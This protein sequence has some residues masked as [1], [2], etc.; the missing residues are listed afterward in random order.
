M[1]TSHTLRQPALPRLSGLIVACLAATWLIWGS[2]YLAIKWALVSLPP[3]FQMGTRFLAAA[4]VL[5]AWAAWHGARWPN[6]AQWLSAGVLGALMVLGG[7]G[8]TALAQTHVSSGLI[9]AFI[10]ISPALIALMSLAYGKRPSRLET[11]GIVLG[12]VGVIALV[13]GHGF[14]AS[15]AGWLLQAVAC[16][17]WSLGTVWSVNGLPG[18]MKLKLAQGAAGWASQMACGGLM[19]LVV[20]LLLA[21]QPV[22]PPDPRALASWLYTVVAGTLVAYVAYMVLIERV[23]PA[24]ASSYAFVNPVMGMALG[25]TLGGELISG[26]EWLAAGIITAGVVLLVLGKR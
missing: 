20:S 19:L 12:L 15:P 9:V 8:M 18:G 17:S 21:E 23:S 4:V 6:R 26:G 7:Y 10:A 14:S 11:A 22:L 1:N 2:T 13:R 16:V 25:A 24:L 5:A 3:F